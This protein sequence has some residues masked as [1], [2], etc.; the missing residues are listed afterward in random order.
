MSSSPEAS[1]SRQVDDR[2][3]TV[4]KKTVKPARSTSNEERLPK[5][6]DKSGCLTKTKVMGLVCPKQYKPISTDSSKPKKTTTQEK[7]SFH[8]KVNSSF[9]FRLQIVTSNDSNKKFK[10]EL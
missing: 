6:T 1:T 5:T 9:S 7:K 10:S 3:I 4:R 8:K 2:F